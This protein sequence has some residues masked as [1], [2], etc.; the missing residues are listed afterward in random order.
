[1]LTRRAF[2]KSTGGL[3]LASASLRSQQR[4]SVAGYPAE[5][6]FTSGKQYKDAFNDVELDVIFDASGGAQYRVPAFW[7]GGQTWRVRFAAPEP[8]RYSFRTESND[9]ANR[10]LHNQ[11]GTLTVTPFEGDNPLYRHGLICVADDRRHFQ[12]DR[13]SCGNRDTDCGWL[14]RGVSWL[15][16]LGS[17]FRRRELSD[18]RHRLYLHGPEG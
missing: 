11:R 1:M 4:E 16:R 14:H 6:L 3:L 12:H 10:D 17:E 18:G 13:Q 9:A 5:W 8:G 7:A 2:C 15:I